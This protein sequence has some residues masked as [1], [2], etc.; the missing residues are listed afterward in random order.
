MGFSG[1]A[2]RLP[3]AWYQRSLLLALWPLV[4]LSWLFGLLAGLRRASYRHGVLRSHRLPVPVIVVGNIAVGGSGK[5]PIALWLA[6][7]LRARGH[8]P[9]IVLSLIHI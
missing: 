3:R 8:R 5:T 9:G 7:T 6:D 2:P 1:L 4:P